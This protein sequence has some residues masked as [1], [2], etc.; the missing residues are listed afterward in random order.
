MNSRHRILA[1]ALAALLIIVM[2]IV[3]AKAQA[4][5]YSPSPLSYYSGQIDTYWPSFGKENCLARQDFLIQILPGGCSPAVIR[6]DLLE[7]QDVPVFCQLTG[8]KIN[9]LIEVP[10]ITSI[11]FKGQQLPKEIAGIGFHPARAALQTYGSQLLGSPVLNN[12][13]YLVVVVRNQPIEKN[14]TE[15]IEAN[16]TALIQYNAEKALGI[17]KAGFLLPL[18][19]LRFYLSILLLTMRVVMP[20]SASTMPIL[21]SRLVLPPIPVLGNPGVAAP[22][23]EPVMFTRQVAVCPAELT[24]TEDV[25]A[26][27]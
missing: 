25:P 26:L 21:R 16:L 15:W 23:T 10:E 20:L 22:K 24:M 11:S 27:G 5:S 7:E 3:Y 4:Y 18:L 17:G 8:I 19:G 9:P 14:M 13:G 6:S 1:G 2:A 12:F